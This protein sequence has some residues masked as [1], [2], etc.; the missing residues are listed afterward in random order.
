VN[1]Q[2]KGPLRLFYEH[3][4]T[5]VVVM[6]AAV[7]AAFLISRSMA[8]L[9]R[10]QAKGFLP[11]GADTMSLSTETGNV[12]TGPRLPQYNTDIQ[13]S[14]L[15]VARSTQIRERV[16]ARIP[17]RE[18]KDLE[19]RVDLAID[20]YNLL[21]VTV[22]DP[23]PETAARI[24]NA[25]LDELQAFL[26]EQN[27]AEID[28]KRGVL[29]EAIR[30]TEEELATAEREWTD[31]QTAHGSAD[32]GAEVSS[33]V[34]RIGALRSAIGDLEVQLN[35]LD[36]QLAAVTAQRDARLEEFRE[37]SRTRVPNPRINDLKQQILSAET[38]YRQL[39]LRY[40]DE[41]PEVK[42]VLARLDELRNQL[43]KEEMTPYQDGA[44]TL[45]RDPI[46]E[47]ME[48]RIHDLEVQRVSLTRQLEERRRLLDEALAEY[49]TLPEYKAGLDVIQQRLTRFQNLLALQRARLEEFDL[50]QARTPNFILVTDRA[51]PGEKPGLPNIPLNLAAAAVLGLV[52]GTVLVVGAD[53]IRNFQEVAPW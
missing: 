27:K 43:A 16:A 14:L 8:P 23:E 1:P 5:L 20:K 17:G 2:E 18:A 36:D 52:L 51:L 9:Y 34:T 10:A 47:E 11:S 7:L 29:V 30:S 46:R 35:T 31:F 53:R 22:W 21:V 26:D 33:L 19:K 13:D 37:S 28:K 4:Y 48:K 39:R 15:G 32:Y 12:P 25:W 50:Q 42:R 38:S 45:T 49:R 6:A 44:I 24:A 3:A 40:K 41:H